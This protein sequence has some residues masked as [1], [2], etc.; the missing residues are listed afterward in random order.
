MFIEFVG[1]VKFLCFW[2]LVV[3]AFSAAVRCQHRA[4]RCCVCSIERR[5]PRQ[6]LELLTFA[7]P[8]IESL[9]RLHRR[10][11]Q[12]GPV[13]YRA[14]NGR[15]RGFLAIRTVPAGRGHAQV[16]LVPSVSL[17]SISACSNSTPLHAQL[18]EQQ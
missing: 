3:R 18:K 11:S 4:L 2:G 10:Q 15:S 6:A 14:P 12:G 7:L 13:P 5:S 16:V 8:L 17:C 9:F 1:F